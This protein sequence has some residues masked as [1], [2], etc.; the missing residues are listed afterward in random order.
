MTTDQFRKMTKP[1]SKRDK[2]AIRQYMLKFKVSEY[3]A[4]RCVFSL[5]SKKRGT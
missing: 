3:V 5:K 2:N 1:I 4:E